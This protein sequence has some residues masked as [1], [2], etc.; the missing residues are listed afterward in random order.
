MVVRDETLVGHHLEI[1]DIGPDRRAG[2]GIVLL[3]ANATEEGRVEPEDRATAGV[4]DLDIDGTTTAMRVTVSIAIERRRIRRRTEV[5]V[6]IEEAGQFARIVR[7][8]RLTDLLR[9]I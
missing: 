9:L 4:C 7:K 6:V 3:H 5:R 8:R 1:I 2:V